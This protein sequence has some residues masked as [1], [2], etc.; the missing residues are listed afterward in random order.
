MSHFTP[1]HMNNAALYFLLKPGGHTMSVQMARCSQ[2]VNAS[3]LVQDS[4][5]QLKTAAAGPTTLPGMN[6]GHVLSIAVHL[7]AFFP[8]VDLQH[9]FLSS[10]LPVH[11]KVAH[12]ATP[13]GSNSLSPMHP[14]FPTGM[15]LQGC[16]TGVQHMAMSLGA[17]QGSQSQ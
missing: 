10:L 15:N 7:A 12:R 5:A 6:R 9:K 13:V 4:L 14:C 2:Q 3:C 8:S 17:S 11:G 16:L 1:A